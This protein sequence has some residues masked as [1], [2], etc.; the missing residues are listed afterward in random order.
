[1]LQWR[2]WFPKELL[3][4]SERNLWCTH[5]YVTHKVN[6]F[7]VHYISLSEQD[8]SYLGNLTI[9]V[10][11]NEINIIGGGQDFLTQMVSFVYINVDPPSKKGDAEHHV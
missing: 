2:Y 4:L 5:N 8:I 3:S 1:M 10:D 7:I 9:T 6:K 11:Y